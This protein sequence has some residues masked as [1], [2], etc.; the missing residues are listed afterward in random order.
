MTD[1]DDPRSFAT[2]PKALAL[3]KLSVGP[4]QGALLY[5]LYASSEAKSWPATDPYLFAI[6]ATIGCAVPILA[7]N[8]LGRLRSVVL[9]CWLVVASILCAIVA[10][11]HIYRGGSNLA[12]DWFSLSLPFMSSAL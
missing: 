3:T 10:A 5:F 12:T 8:A 7:I 11:Q 4:I 6:L 1:A 2:S 9:V